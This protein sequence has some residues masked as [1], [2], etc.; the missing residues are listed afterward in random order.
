[1]LVRATFGIVYDAIERFLADDGWMVASYIALTTLMSLFP[2][3]IFV[4]ALAGFFGTQSLSNEVA[5]LIFG[6]WPAA[7]AEPMAE[8]VRNVL[9][10]PRGG[11]LT[12]GAV[13][14]LYFAS[15]AIE[16]LRTGLNRAYHFTEIRPWWIL[17]LYS[18]AFVGMM[19]IALLALAFLVV[20]WLGIWARLVGSFPELGHFHGLLSGI[21]AL[22]APLFLAHRYLPVR[23]MRFLDIAPGVAVTVVCSIIF[24]WGFGL[25]LASFPLNYASMY[26]GLGSVMAALVFLYSIAA[27]FVF[28]GELNA[29]IMHAR[30]AHKSA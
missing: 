5:R 19:S 10:Q 28:G 13:F 11:L 27:I 26:A 17:R 12:F 4:A 29:A 14:A 2:L 15:S 23:R 6:T 7:V 21:L 22:S 24:G 1:M 8:E 20:V 16:A 3:L 25:Y 30:E 18:I 9:T